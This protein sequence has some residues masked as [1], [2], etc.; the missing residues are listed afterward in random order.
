MTVF[1]RAC[2]KCSFMKIE[3]GHLGTL[4]HVMPLGLRPHRGHG[5][6][7]TLQLTTR[8]WRA[9]AN[10][11]RRRHNC[12]ARESRTRPIRPRCHACQQV[13]RHPR[14]WAAVRPGC[15]LPPPSMRTWRKILRTAQTCA[16]RS[17]QRR[18]RGL[19]GGPRYGAVGIAPR[20]AAEWVQHSDRCSL[21]HLRTRGV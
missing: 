17:R 2:Y 20:Q 21:T 5:L 3:G 10:A 19:C 15:C 7:T 9:C 13:H 14:G 11:A 4:S 1:T 8:K 6:G 12:T 18:G 16:S